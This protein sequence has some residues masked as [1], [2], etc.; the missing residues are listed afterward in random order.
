MSIRRAVVVVAGALGLAAAL[1]VTASA[2]PGRSAPPQEGPPGEAAVLVAGNAARPPAVTSMPVAGRCRAAGYGA[3]FYAPGTGKTVALTFDDGP[4]RSTAAILAVLARYRVPA[5]FFNIGVNMAARPSLVREEV[6]RG[7]AMGNHTWN[8][9]DLDS[10]S[11][12][13]QAAELDRASAE[14]RSIAGTV[15]CAFRPPYGDYDATTLRLAQQRRMGVW[16]W[17]VDTQDWM[18]DGS[19]SAF[20]E[21]RIIRLAEQEGGALHHPIVLMHNQPAGNPATVGALPTI[22]RFFRAHGYRFVTL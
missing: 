7:F 8:H 2:G 10:L 5:T 4:G 17:S 12:A 22:I 13:Q 6:R 20:W 3:R 14:Q 21:H 15:P 19:G 11:A 16:L 9:P 1:S 18:A